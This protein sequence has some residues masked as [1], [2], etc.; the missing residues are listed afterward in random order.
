MLCKEL[1]PSPMVVQFPHHQNTHTYSTGCFCHLCQISIRISFSAMKVVSLL[2][3]EDQ[4][5]FLK[6]VCT[7]V[8]HLLFNYLLLKA[9]MSP[10][11]HDLIKSCMFAWTIPNKYFIQLHYN[12]TSSLSPLTV[13]QIMIIYKPIVPGLFKYKQALFLSYLEIFRSPT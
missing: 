3:L 10:H 9:G 11:Q 6:L 12:T 4:D 5:S 1:V 7:E 13:K 2:R 8:Q